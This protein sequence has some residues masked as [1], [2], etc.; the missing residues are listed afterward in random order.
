MVMA[1]SENVRKTQEKNTRVLTGWV[2]GHKG[3]PGNEEAD[4]LAKNQLGKSTSE[5]DTW[6]PCG[7]KKLLED[8]MKEH[9][10]KTCPP[11]EEYEGQPSTKPPAYF[12]LPRMIASRIAQISVQ[13]SYMKG[14]TCYKRLD[15]ELCTECSCDF[16]TTQ[17]AIFE[18]PAKEHLREGFREEFTLQAMKD[19]E[20]LSKMLGVYIQ[21]SCTGYPCVDV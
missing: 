13:K 15:P 17:H 12:S 7:V 3:V 11:R 10:L 16:E 18:C 19:S 9:W 20:E 5:A 4:K 8:F 14:H 2:P 21:R 1:T 6:T